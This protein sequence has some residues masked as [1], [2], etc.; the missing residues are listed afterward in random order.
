MIGCGNDDSIHVLAIEHR[1]IVA[2]AL[3]RV[4]LLFLGACDGL[5]GVL[6]VDV[7]DGDDLGVG[8]FEERVQE[9]VAATARANQT[10]PDLVVGS[11]ARATAGEESS[12]PAPAA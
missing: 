8:L 7:G 6:V 5:F 2:G 3:R 4:A 11:L 12:V 9:L 10:E 1:S